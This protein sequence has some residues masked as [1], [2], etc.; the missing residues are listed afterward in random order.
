MKTPLGAL[1]CAYPSGFLAGEDA[2]PDHGAGT[3]LSVGRLLPSRAY[4]CFTG[5]NQCVAPAQPTCPRYGSDTMPLR[6]IFS[7][8]CHDGSG[9]AIHANLEALDAGIEPAWRYAWLV[10][11]A[12]V[13][14][15]LLLMET[16]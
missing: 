2:Q 6:K 5:Q 7:C 9:G 10:V 16:V 1:D 15:A 14:V 12:D 4:F 11:E 13:V 3:Q 8:K